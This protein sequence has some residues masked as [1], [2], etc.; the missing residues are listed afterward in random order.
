MKTIENV[1]AKG[2]PLPVK[3]GECKIED[4]CRCFYE[5]IC[6]REESESILNRSRAVIAALKKDELKD[7]S[8]EKYWKYYNRRHQPLGTVGNYNQQTQ[9]YEDGYAG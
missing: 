1:L 5:S 3:S 7:F 2:T 6:V 4:C 8:L 9:Q